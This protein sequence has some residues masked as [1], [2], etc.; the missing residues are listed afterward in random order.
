MT[1]LTMEDVNLGFRALTGSQHILQGAGNLFNSGYE[2]GNCVVM[3]SAK[4]PLM[5]DTRGNR[6]IDTGMGAGSMILGHAPQSV[7]N[8]ISTQASKGTIFVHPAKSTFVLKKKF[9]RTYQKNSAV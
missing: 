5:H 1:Y 4:G 9:L 2:E 6:Y 7:V 8:K 3:E